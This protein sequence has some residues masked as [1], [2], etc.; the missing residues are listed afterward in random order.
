MEILRK[1]PALLLATLLT[2]GL[3]SCGHYQLGTQAKLSFST[4]YVAPVENTSGLPQTT[5]LV[6]TQLREKLLRDPR[7]QLVADPAAAQAILEVKLVR[8]SREITA[9]RPEPDDTGLARK[10]DLT[11]HAELTLRD[12]RG[13][14]TLIASRPISA[15]RQVFSTAGTAGAPSDQSAA[16]YQTLPLLADSLATR[17]ASAVLDTW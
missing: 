7:I 8:H 4:L 6:A 17:I 5:A 12:T 10:S 1:L 2:F 16:A 11:L 3:T 9:F 14:Q 13:N 15:T